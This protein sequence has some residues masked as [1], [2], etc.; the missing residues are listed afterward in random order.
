MLIETCDFSCI[1]VAIENDLIP[2]RIKNST[3]Y[4]L[5]Y[6][7]PVTN[8]NNKNTI[9]AVAADNGLM[10]LQPCHYEII[11]VWF[12]IRSGEETT[13]D[14]EYSLMGPAVDEGLFSVCRKNGY[15]KIHGILDREKAASYEVSVYGCKECIVKFFVKM[16]MQV[17]Q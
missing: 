11:R 12:Q 15:V 16:M 8:K 4:Q 2:I 9:N 3:Y 1:S 6:K 10:M 7:H 14:I 13:S 17:K 5:C